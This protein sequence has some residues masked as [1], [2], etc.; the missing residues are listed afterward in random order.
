MIRIETLQMKSIN[1]YERKGGMDEI[2]QR[3]E[4]KYH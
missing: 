1:K 3:F 2:F 4:V